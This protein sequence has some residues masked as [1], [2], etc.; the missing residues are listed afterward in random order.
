MNRRRLLSGLG[1]TALLAG[2]GGAATVFRP[3]ATPRRWPGLTEDHLAELAKA[4]LPRPRALFIGNS[5]TLHHDLA[6]LVAARA[7]QDGVALSVAAAAARGARLIETWRIAALRDLLQPGTWDVVVLQDLT[8]MPLRAVDRLGSSFVTRRIAAA[9]APAPVLLYAPPPPASRAAIYRDPG[10]LAELPLGPEDL[11]RRTMAHY[12]GIAKRPGI[13]LAPIPRLWLDDY[14]AARHAEDGHHLSQ[15]GA[16]FV[17]G[18]LW[19]EMRG[20]LQAPA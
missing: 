9:V 15:A 10:V 19:A 4:D 17:A 16:N 2:L 1:T 11:A 6:D 3:H 8:A 7:R 20:L 18:A 5:Q 14:D 13:H 12:G